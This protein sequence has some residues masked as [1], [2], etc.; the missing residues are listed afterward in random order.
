MGG[1]VAVVTGASS[2]IGLAIATA[3]AE[4]GAR[5]VLSARGRD[6]LDEAAAR[7]AAAGHEV[8]PV[9]ADVAREADVLA[10]FNATAE[11]FGTPDVVVN[12]AGMAT[13]TPTPDLT[14]AE[15][16]G[17]LDVNVTG[18]FLCSREAFRAMR[19]R[20][21]GR[22]GGRIINVG[23]VSARVP[24]PNS[25]PYTTS[26]FA[27]EG[28]TRAFALDG[29]AH[30]IAA[31]VLHPGNTRSEIWKGREGAAAREGIMQA[32]D[33]ARVAVLMATLPPEVNLLESVI[34]PVTMPFLGRG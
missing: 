27:L 21:D 10:L 33:V 29:R 24:R 9:A 15:F 14:L 4:A 7:L 31:S 1:L 5:V 2:G 12:N 32:A 22:G 19:A 8:H 26:K 28:M 13:R 3:Y 6:R 30:G 17:C 18:A 25:V 34:L 20:A 11:R 16:Q 23:S